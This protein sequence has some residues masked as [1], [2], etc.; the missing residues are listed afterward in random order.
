MLDVMRWAAKQF[1]DCLLDSPLAEQARIYLAERELSGETVRRF[2]LG[3]APASWEWLTQRAAEASL[4][5]DILEK[6]GLIGKR[7]EGPGYYDRFR[8]RVM[9]PIRDARGQ[10]VGFGGRILPSSPSSTEAAKY[11]NSSET[12]LFSKSENLY[13][14]DHARDAAVKAGYLAVVEGYT[15]VLMAHQ[16]GIG[17]VVATMG[18]A[19]NERHIQQLRR[20]VN[21]VILVFDA[22]EGGDTGVDRALE[23]FVKSDM[24]LL[25]ARL[26]E[27]LDPCDLLAQKGAVPFQSA[28]TEAVDVLE[29]KLKRVWSAEGTSVEGRRRAVDAVLGILALAPEARTIKLELMVNRIA[30]RAGLKEE[31]L[32]ARLKELRESQQARERPGTQGQ[33][34]PTP[35]QP[36]ETPPVAAAR[37]EVELMEVLLAQPDLVGPARAEIEPGRI[38]HPRIRLLLEGLYDL[39]E[40]GLTPDL[41]HLRPRIDNPRLLAKAMEWQERGQAKT[42]RQAYWQDIRARFRQLRAQSLKLDLKSQLHAAGDHAAAV[43]VLRRVQNETREN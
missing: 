23:V 40:E 22:D 20:V 33:G 32:W 10:A 12:I 16:T 17:Q 19:L 8:D 15:D 25:V 34:P 5:A 6:V 14:I 29:Y 7:K 27:G 28:L 11:Y 1:H 30:L 31:N 2:G 38:E 37:H 9:F 41:D 4:S 36:Q 39:H 35:E 3:F 21:K 26:P 13:G 18:T 42:D 24:E 43:E